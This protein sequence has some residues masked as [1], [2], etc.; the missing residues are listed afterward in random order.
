[1][2][3]LSASAYGGFKT[4]ENLQIAT[5]GVVE[6]IRHAQANAQTGKNDSA[7]GVKVLTGEAVVFK[8]SDYAGRVASADQS[9]GLPGDISVTGLSEIVFAKVSGA[10]NT[11]GTTT[12]TNESGVQ[13]IFINDKGTLTY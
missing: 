5:M 7:W 13:H 10:P 6:A 3:T 9:L 12:L 4:H 8:G 1:L 11:T 2:L